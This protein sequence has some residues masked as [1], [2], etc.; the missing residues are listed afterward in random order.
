MNNFLNT[1]KLTFDAKSVNEGFARSVVS[2]FFALLN[3]TL[4]ETE[5]LKTAVSEA[6]TNAIVHGYS[7]K[8]QGKI[9]IDC[10]LKED[11]VYVTVTDYGKGIE[12][13]SKA[14]EPFYTTC[15]NGDRSGM[16]FTVMQAFCNSV[17]VKSEGGTTSV[18]LVK[19]IAG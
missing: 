9:D 14:M 4:E 15:K 8:Q 10:G 12:N 16:G 6:V 7:A 5:D 1:M 18:T 3:P 17:E 2:G 11:A 13:V 19:R